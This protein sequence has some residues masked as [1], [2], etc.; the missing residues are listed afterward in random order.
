MTVMHI[1]SYDIAGGSDYCALV[2]HW[3][4]RDAPEN[5]SMEENFIF[6]I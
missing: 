6:E 4:N 1:A 5:F 3:S 2:L